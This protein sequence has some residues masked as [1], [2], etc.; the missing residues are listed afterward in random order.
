MNKLCIICGESFQVFHKKPN[1]IYKYVRPRKCMTCSRKCSKI[2][3][4]RMNINRII[5]RKIKVI[6]NEK[7]G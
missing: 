2:Y 5:M 3:S 7:M 1:G 4:Y 6:E